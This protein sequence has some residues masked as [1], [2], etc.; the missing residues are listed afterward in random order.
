MLPKLSHRTKDSTAVFKNL[1]TNLAKL[2]F[3]SA[4]IC[5][6]ILKKNKLD[7]SLYKVMHILIK[8]TILVIKVSSIFLRN[9]RVI[10]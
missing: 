2:K 7:L 10:N 4:V 6:L 3:S 5:Q 1:W 8:L 9:R